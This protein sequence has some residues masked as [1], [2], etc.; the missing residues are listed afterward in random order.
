MYIKNIH[1]EEIEYINPIH[2]TDVSAATALEPTLEQIEE[3]WGKSRFTEALYN[4]LPIG[5]SRPTVIVKG[6]EQQKGSVDVANL[7][8]QQ[9][10]TIFENGKANRKAMSKSKDGDCNPLFFKPDDHSKHMEHMKVTSQ[11]YLEHMIPHHQVAIDMSKRLLLHTNNTYLIS[12]CRELIIKQ[13]GEIYYMNNLLENKFIHNSPL[14][15]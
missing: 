3:F 13:Q 2:I 6:V 8:Y 1:W 11:S 7:T 9:A 5:Q 14:L 12:F 15:S 10:K 4:Y